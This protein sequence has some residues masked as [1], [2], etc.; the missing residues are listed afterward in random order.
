[1]SIIRTVMV[2]TFTITAVYFL[3]RACLFMRRVRTIG[4]FH[5]YRLYMPIAGLVV[6][7]GA[8]A[9][10]AAPRRWYACGVVLL[11]GVLIALREIVWAIRSA[12][13]MIAAE[14]A[15]AA[16]RSRFRQHNDDDR[17]LLSQLRQNLESASWACKVRRFR[18]A[19]RCL[20]GLLDNLKRLQGQRA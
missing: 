1:M 7:V 12:A 9:A 2:L 19:H 18:D 17:K 10:C 8:A 5:H 15:L 6:S 20:K 13:A 11:V 16:E 3:L 14:G 4:Y